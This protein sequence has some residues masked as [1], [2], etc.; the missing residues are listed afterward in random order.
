[1]LKIPFDEDKA[2]ET[3]LYIAN[4]CPIKDIY[5]ILKIQFFADCKH[6]DKC[7]RFITG[8]H[9]IAMKNGPVASNAY[10]FLKVARGEPVYIPQSM[11][12]KIKE[13][14]SVEGFSVKS[15]R[16]AA[17]DYLSQ[18]DIDCL[19]EAIA[20]NGLLSFNELNSK[21]H[22]DLWK[23]AN[24]NDEISFADFVRCSPNSEMLRDYLNG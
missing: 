3:L 10:N 18:S 23:S 16:A 1:M 7:S 12:V 20:E 17:V 6:L 14:L 8:D 9:Y 22:G 19:N 13:A 5:H 24:L 2:L 21:S 11:I 4:H 15:K